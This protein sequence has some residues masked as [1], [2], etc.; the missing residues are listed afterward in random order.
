MKKEMTAKLIEQRENARRAWRSRNPGYE[1]Q[2]N[3]TEERKKYMEQYTK[4]HPDCQKEKSRRWR[5]KD[6]QRARMAK[7]E[8]HSIRRAR[9]ANNP[10][11]PISPLLVYERDGGMCGICGEEIRMSDFTMDHIIP[12]SKGGGHVYANVHS[13]HR[14]CNVRRGNRPLDVLYSI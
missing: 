12:I 13:A 14:A 8:E 6:R 2:R 1:V 7:K 10:V 4:D 11:E 3:Q 5:A 9:I